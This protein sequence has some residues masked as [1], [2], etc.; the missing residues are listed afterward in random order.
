VDDPFDDKVIRLDYTTNFCMSL[1]NNVYKI[2]I[3]KLYKDYK[4]KQIKDEKVVSSLSTWLRDNNV[5]GSDNFII[6]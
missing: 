4:E 6:F 5:E 1:G 3:V 2:Y